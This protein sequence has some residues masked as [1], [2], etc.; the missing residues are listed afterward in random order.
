VDLV[1]E[2][3]LETTLD[4]FALLVVPPWRYLAPA[5]IARLLEYV[6]HGGALLLIGPQANAHFREHPGLSGPGEITQE[7]RWIC[8]EGRLAGVQGRVQAVENGSETE[9]F[10]RIFPHNAPDGASTPAASLAR[11]GRG[12][13]GAVHFDLGRRYRHSRTAVMRDFLSG[14]VERLVPKPLVRVRGSHLVDVTLRRQNGRLMIHLINTG[15]PHNDATALTFDEIP[16]LGPLAI[17]VRGERPRAVSLL[18]EDAPLPYEY[19]DGITS[20]QL[21]RLELHAT[22]AIQ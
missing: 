14:L 20:L 21:P 15:G 22:I 9:P 16:P 6:R 19:A 13:I 4:E 5:F 2:H 11:Q 18:P 10:G 3:H 8:H 17:T 12:W 7:P 1:S